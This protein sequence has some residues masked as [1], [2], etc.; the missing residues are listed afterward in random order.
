MLKQ[1]TIKNFKS[2]RDEQEIALSRL[3]IFTGANSSGKSTILQSILLMKQTLQYG[4]PSRTLVLNGPILKLGT[5][6]EILNERTRSK[7]E[8]QIQM[9]MADGI[10]HREKENG[11]GAPSWFENGSFYSFVSRPKITQIS[12]QFLWDTSDSFGEQGEEISEMESFN[13]LYPKLRRGRLSCV[14]QGADAKLEW[15]YVAKTADNDSL[16]SPDNE[17]AEYRTNLDAVS[18][19]E[20]KRKKPGT[21]IDVSYLHHSFPSHVAIEYD[22]KAERAAGLAEAI[23]GPNTLL[24]QQI[25]TFGESYVPKSVVDKIIEW[26]KAKESKVEIAAKSTSV[27][28]LSESL[29]PI[30][31]ENVFASLSSALSMRSVGASRRSELSALIEEAFLEALPE[32]TAREY[33]MPDDLRYASERARRFLTDGIR[34]L[35]P[36]RDEPKPVYPIEALEQPTVV[37]YRGEHTAAVLDL[38]SKR[39]I[40]FVSPESLSSGV[41]RPEQSSLIEAVNRWSEYMG[42]ATS[43]LTKENSVFGHQLQIKTDDKTHGARDLT[44]VGVGVSQVLPILVMTLLAPS[45]SLLIFEQP[46]LHL[47][48]KV[49]ARLADF[50]LAATHSGKQC[51]LETHSEYLVDRVRRRIAEDTENLLENHTKIYFVERD[52]SD[53][54]CRNVN[55]SAFGSVEDWPKDFFD[56]TPREAQ[57]IL[58]AALRKSDK[59]DKSEN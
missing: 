1:W 59:S 46:E 32:E 44:N 43:V 20:I 39:Q 42:V 11:V 21:I 9:T 54:K 36:L 22:R 12:S 51:I 52:G 50:F 56:Q 41:M 24:S 17:L 5:F 29:Q 48:P 55:V 10:T 3:N 58:R 2:F 4:P 57:A 37:G 40:T 35:G 7:K 45:G 26:A 49:Q 6:E 27:S 31:R 34:Y 18:A 15:E 14:V 53:S 33:Q 13:Q 38:N 8:L 23:V 19:A 47:H 25:R 16:G 28:E 30:F